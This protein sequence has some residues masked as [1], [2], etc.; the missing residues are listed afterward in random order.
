[1]N[2][3][4]PEIKIKSSIWIEIVHLG[5]IVYTSFS[6]TLELAFG[7]KIE[8]FLLA[9]EVICCMDLLRRS[10]RYDISICHCPSSCISPV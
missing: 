4:K 3:E 1:L 8:T 2:L 7:L 10:N 9:M 6:I 5:L